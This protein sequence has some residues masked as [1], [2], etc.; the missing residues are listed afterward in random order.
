M[1]LVHTELSAWCAAVHWG[2]AA[3][4]WPFSPPGS[5]MG[6]AVARDPGQMPSEPL[7]ETVQEPNKLSGGPSKVE[8][9]KPQ[10]SARSPARSSARW[11]APPV[12]LSAFTGVGCHPLFFILCPLSGEK[13]MQVPALTEHVHSAHSASVLFPNVPM[14]SCFFFSFFFQIDNLYKSLSTPGQQKDLRMFSI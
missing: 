3:V 11:R 7:E 8:T 13:Q 14:K 12:R 6:S 9:G 10:R 2:W 4:S 5:Q 1:A